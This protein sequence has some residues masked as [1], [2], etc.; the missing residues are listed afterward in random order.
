MFWKVQLNPQTKYTEQ[1][2]PSFIIPFKSLTIDSYIQRVLRLKLKLSFTFHG[3]IVVFWVHMIQ[4]GHRSF[5]RFDLQLIMRDF[6]VVFWVQMIQFESRSFLWFNLQLDYVWVVLLYKFH[7][8]STLLQIHVRFV[9]WK[10]ECWFQFWLLKKQRKLEN[11]MKLKVG[12]VV[13]KVP[14]LY[15]YWLLTVSQFIRMTKIWF[16]LVAVAAF[17]SFSSE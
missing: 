17:F 3:F 1:K 10:Y 11:Q 12:L 9:L 5:L 15:S 16:G 7:Y 6:T 14:T 4:F 13:F 2:I 8:L